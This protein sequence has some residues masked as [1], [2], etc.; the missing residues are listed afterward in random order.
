VLVKFVSSLVF[1]SLLLAPGTILA[2]KKNG[3]SGSFTEKTQDCHPVHHRSK[4]RSG[5]IS[6]QNHEPCAVCDFGVCTIPFFAAEVC[7]VRVHNKEYKKL[8]HTL[9]SLQ[10][11]KTHNASPPLKEHFSRYTFVPLP[12]HKNW[13]AVFSNFL[14]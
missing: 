4:S 2:C 9:H 1:L 6:E 3:T 7:L 13:Q 10:E 8:D 11:V 14:N 12:M 5:E